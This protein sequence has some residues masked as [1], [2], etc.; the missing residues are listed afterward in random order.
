M[1]RIDTHN[2]S[3][4]P[5]WLPLQINSQKDSPGREEHNNPHFRSRMAVPALPV[6]T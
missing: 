2:S 1:L 3:P 5:A 6:L 4:S